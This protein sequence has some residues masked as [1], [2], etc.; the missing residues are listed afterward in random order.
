VPKTSPAACEHERKKDTSKAVT[1]APPQRS[2]QKLKA[3]APKPGAGAAAADSIRVNNP[4]PQYTRDKFRGRTSTSYIDW[5][6]LMRRALGL[7]VLDCPRCHDRVKPVV[8]IEQEEVCSKILTHL[9]LPLRPEELA[10]GAV[11]Y[12]VTAEPAFDSDEWVQDGA[13]LSR[14]PP[15]NWD[16]IDPPAPAE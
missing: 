6:T 2:S 3:A 8:V 13:S 16:G 11:V 1:T 5:A 10:D 4:S 9:K 12:D 7:D 14:G 15:C